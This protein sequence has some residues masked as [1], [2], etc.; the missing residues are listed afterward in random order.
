MEHYA[1][2]WQ[3]SKRKM[4][5]PWVGEVRKHTVWRPQQGGQKLKQRQCQRVAAA[6][7]RKVLFTAAGFTHNMKRKPLIS[8]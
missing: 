5:N 6:T 1:E 4:R 7:D 3:Q 2:S 8:C